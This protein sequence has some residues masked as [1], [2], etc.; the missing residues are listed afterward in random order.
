MADDEAARAE[1][2]RRIYGPDDLAERPAFAGGFINFGYWAGIP[3]DGELTVDQRIASQRALYDLVLDSLT[4]TPDDRVLEVGCGRG[5]GAR[6]VLVRAPR[7]LD[8]LDLVPEQVARA[9]RSTPEAT[10]TLGSASYIPFPDNTF[11]RLLSVE[12]AQHFED[13][14]AFAHESARVLAPGGRLAVTTFFARHDDAGP[15]L[16]ELLDT[17]ATGLDLAHPID[18]FTADL[19][20]AGF[21]DVRA[22]RIG[23]HV[24]AGLDRWL[25]LGDHPDRWDRRWIRAA[26]RGLLDYYLVTANLP[27]APQPA[28]SGT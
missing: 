15:A 4:I 21:A 22:D 7:S 16:A 10:F 26:E 17:F 19:R 12:A 18:R 1:R 14:T 25:A 24:W 28:G 13:L 9:Q 5:R 11:D 8:G 23:E 20:A 6:E 27:A 2:R 3:L